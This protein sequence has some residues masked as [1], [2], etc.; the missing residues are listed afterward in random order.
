MG[1]NAVTIIRPHPIIADL[2]P[3][4]EFY[5]VHSYYPQPTKPECVYATCEYGIIF[6]AAI[7]FRNLFAVQFH[8][9]KSG[10]VGLRLLENFTRWD[11]GDTP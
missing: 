4:D 9:E 11:V 5:F 3:G 8:A 7:G 1:W 10:P 6:P 2:Q